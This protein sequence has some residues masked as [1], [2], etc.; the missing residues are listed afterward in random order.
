[1]LQ[2]MLLVV[3]A[4]VGLVLLVTAA[5]SL[6]PAK[7]PAAPPVTVP[8]VAKSAR[9]DDSRF[10]SMPVAAGQR[11]ETVHV[12]AAKNCTRDEAMRAD[13]LTADLKSRGISVERTDGVRFPKVSPD[14]MAST[15]RV[16]Q[17][18]L[19]IVF[20]SGAAANNPSLDDVL[21]E[22]QRRQT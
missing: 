9:A 1:M 8:S 10:V 19:P 16:M 14:Q 13:R 12:V 15:Q 2:A 17:G 7:T 5:R 22:Y 21:H 11:A 3:G 4:A 18:P 6:Q 20:V